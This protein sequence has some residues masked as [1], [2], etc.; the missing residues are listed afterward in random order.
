MHVMKRLMTLCVGVALVLTSALAA[1]VPS[2]DLAGSWAFDV[3]K[4][5]PKDGPALVVITLSDKD[6]TTRFGSATARVMPFKLDG[7]ETAVGEN[8]KT[9]A[10]W[11]GSKLEATVASPTYTE[12]ITFFREGEYLVME[13][14]SREHGPLKFYFK[15][16]PAGL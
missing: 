1:Q 2:K 10:V 6:F 8:Y 4:S 9:K 11:K 14:S 5:K 15:K 12:T 7:T 3:E 16:A 13:G